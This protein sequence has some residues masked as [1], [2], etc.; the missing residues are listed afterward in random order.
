MEFA[1][2]EESLVDSQETL[3]KFYTLLGAVRLAIAFPRKMN[4]FLFLKPFGLTDRY[5]C[6]ALPSPLLN[7][8]EIVSHGAG[9]GGGVGGAKCK[10]TQK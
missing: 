7:G 1:S 10:A 2:S 8:F 6:L 5:L 4:S 9:G 3:F